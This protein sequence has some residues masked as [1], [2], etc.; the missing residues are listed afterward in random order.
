MD[1]LSLVS[2]RAIILEF[3]FG[4]ASGYSGRYQDEF[5]EE[6]SS[7]KLSLFIIYSKLFIFNL[8]IIVNYFYF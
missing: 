2:R 8:F 4:A 1:A 6:M 7:H 5:L 3:D